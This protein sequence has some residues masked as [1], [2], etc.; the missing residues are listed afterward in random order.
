MLRITGR[1]LERA[2]GGRGGRP[3]RGR[4]GRA[5]RAG[6]RWGSSRLVILH[7]VNR[8]IVLV[9]VVLVQAANNGVKGDK[10]IASCDIVSRG[11][12]R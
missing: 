12:S 4:A 11:P 5:G 10:S 1:M 2:A 9:V 3:G 8:Q 7:G 6:S